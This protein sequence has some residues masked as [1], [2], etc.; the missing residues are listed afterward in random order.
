MQSTLK[1][2]FINILE[3]TFYKTKKKRKK[4]NILLITF[5]K[6]CLVISFKTSIKTCLVISLKKKKKREPVSYMC[7][8][9]TA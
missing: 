6:T 3:N 9:A 1:I 2:I 4:E 5:K 7:L 8:V